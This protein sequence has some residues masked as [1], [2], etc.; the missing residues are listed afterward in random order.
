MKNAFRLLSL[1]GAFLLLGSA[2]FAADFNYVVDHTGDD[3]GQAC[4]G[5]AADCSLRSALQLASSDGG[6]TAITFSASGTIT[7]GS[8]LPTVAANTTITGP[9]AGSLT[10]DLSAAAFITFGSNNA[11]TMTALTLANSSSHCV[12]FQ[13]DNITISN[14]TINTCNNSGIL[15][16]GGN[17]SI[18]ISNNTI[19][20][21]GAGGSGIQLGDATNST[22]SGNAITGGPTGITLSGTTGSTNSIT[23]NTITNPT[24]YGISV[25]GTGNYTGTTVTGNTV[26]GSGS[27]SLHLGNFSGSASSNTISNSSGISILV[28]AVGVTTVNS[29]VIN[30]ST[31]HG[32]QIGGSSGHTINSNDI[33]TVSGL[34]SNGIYL[35]S[36]GS[37]LTMTGN[38]VDDAADVGINI[39]NSSGTFSNNTVT[40]STDEGFLINAVSSSTISNNTVNTTANNGFNISGGGGNTLN[41]NA[42]TGSSNNCYLIMSDGNTFTNTTATTCATSGILL[43]DLGGEDASGNSFTTTTVTPGGVVMGVGILTSDTTF[44]GGTISGEILITKSVADGSNFTNNI[45]SNLTAGEISQA[46][47]VHSSDIN[48]LDN[49]TFTTLTVLAGTMDVNF[50]ARVYATR[51]GTSTGLSSSTI[52]YK[53]NN[54]S[55]TSLGT[56]NG[57]GYTSYTSLDAYTKTSSGTS[58]DSYLFASQHNVGYHTASA[59]LSSPNQTI[60]VSHPG[61]QGGAESETTTTT[62]VTITP[63]VTEEETEEVTEEVTLEPVLVETTPEEPVVEELVEES[64]PENTEISEPSETEVNQVSEAVGTVTSTVSQVVSTLAQG[65]QEQAPASTE[66]SVE[67][68]IE[69]YEDSHQNSET[70]E[71]PTIDIPN[72]TEELLAQ[73]REEL[74]SNGVTPENLELTS[75]FDGDLLSDAFQVLHGIPLFEEDSDNDGYT[76]SEEIFMGTNPTE[77]NEAP[78]LPEITNMEGKIVGQWPS[79]RV[80]SSADDVVEIYLVNAET[81]AKVMIGSVSIDARNKGEFN[82]RYPLSNGKYY[83]VPKGKNGFGEAVKFTVDSR[84]GLR[85][86]QVV[87]YDLGKINFENGG[88]LRLGK[89]VSLTLESVDKA[90][91]GFDSGEYLSAFAGANVQIVRGYA[92]PGSVVYLTF[93]SVV[94]SSV[95]IAD[96]KGEFKVELLASKLDLDAERH[97]ILAYATDQKGNFAT[98]VFKFLTGR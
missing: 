63:V 10:I 40:N 13:G 53:K 66:V 78:S 11:I 7:P 15:A 67:S 88:M 79:I 49:V 64:I 91:K 43:A 5:A 70:E 22:I 54:G 68:L 18:T 85:V 60:T 74:E 14:V 33:N 69:D 46:N 95:A 73:T 75:D 77:Y 82:L 72:N 93:K 86:P 94:V 71:S 92:E 47:D 31:S 81:G 89:F 42:V 28:T 45:L 59:T 56:T 97:E 29:N 61:Q 87:G 34:V 32:I 84:I 76:N 50:D 62:V 57:S 98:S 83:A 96:A 37:G 35:L 51:D 2:A 38:T 8:A 3:A 17:D 36:A 52:T 44:D 12:F 41:A 25:A 24:S 27:N 19:S 90:D 80:V 16:N 23:G 6:T 4:T 58:T 48:Y 55:F 20:G 65:G 26:S 30:N 9:G 21:V 39:Y 1:C